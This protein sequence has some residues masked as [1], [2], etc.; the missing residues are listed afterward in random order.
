MKH[1][2]VEFKARYDDLERAR[3]VLRERGAT[4]PTCDHQLDTYFGVDRGRL[5]LRQGSVE[6]ALIHYRR[7]DDRGPKTSDV[8]LYSLP[9]DGH[10]L[11]E[12]LAAALRIQAVVEKRREIWWLGNVKVHLDEVPDLGTFIE[13]EAINSDGL[14][15]EALRAQ[16]DE[17][18]SALRIG[19]DDLVE[20]SYAELS[21]PNAP[22]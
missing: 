13:V 7:P 3:Q 12:T 10:S 9:D 4:G 2:N 6:R 21:G 20:R 14:G 15:V 17:L 22:Q 1:L 19:A 5:K 16:C 8:T 11:R 18:L